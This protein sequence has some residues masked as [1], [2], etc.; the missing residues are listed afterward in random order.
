MFDGMGEVFIIN[1][2]ERTDRLR[3]MTA[4][5]HKVGQRTGKVWKAHKP[6]DAGPFPTIGTRGCFMSHLAVIMSNEKKASAGFV[7]LEDDLDFAGDARER[8]QAIMSDLKERV[9]NWGMFYGAHANVPTKGGGLYEEIAPDVPVL[10]ASFVCFNGWLLPYLS[11]YLYNMLGRPAGDPDGGPMHVDGAY[12]WFRRAHPEVR[13]FVATPVLGWQ[14]PSRTDIHEL[15]WFDRTPVVR[16][17]VSAARSAKR[18]T[19]PR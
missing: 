15:K 14:R 19:T 16:D 1:L 3:Q 8:F 10:T 4:E 13:T 12:G 17:V 9:P 7:L 5:L 18:L 11:V 2:P 6:E